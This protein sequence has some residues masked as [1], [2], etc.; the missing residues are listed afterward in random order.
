MMNQVLRQWKDSDLEP[1]AQM[2][3]DAEVMRYFLAPMTRV[4]AQ[5]AIARMQAAL[6]QRGWGIWAVEVDGDFAGMVGLNVP[7]WSLRTPESSCC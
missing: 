6:E 4:E 2:N 7:R 3:S 1:F 5:A